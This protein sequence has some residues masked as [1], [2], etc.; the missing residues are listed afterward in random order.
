MNTR[1]AV[2]LSAFLLS[3]AASGQSAR[4]DLGS[5]PH[6]G[7]ATFRVWA[8]NATAAAV[9]GEFNGWNSVNHQLALE[10][11]GLWSAEL[12]IPAGAYAYKFVVDGKWLLDPANPATKVVDGVTN[13]LVVAQPPAGETP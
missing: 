8:P 13:S 10:K 11:V 5:M 1:G 2:L 12:R 7:G 3:A 6:A 9:A 4:P